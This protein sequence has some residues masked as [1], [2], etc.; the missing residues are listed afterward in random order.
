MDDRLR[1]VVD[2]INLIKV[3]DLGGVTHEHNTTVSSLSNVGEG[4]EDL[5]P[6]SAGGSFFDVV[7]SHNGSRCS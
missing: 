3:K 7:G 2:E 6:S 4:E 5:V 1:D